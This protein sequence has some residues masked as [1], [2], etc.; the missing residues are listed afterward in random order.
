MF[1][2]FILGKWFFE[3]TITLQS[4]GLQDQVVPLNH[5]NRFGGS[6]TGDSVDDC[7]IHFKKILSEN[8]N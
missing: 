4:I 6:F 7:W 2:L 3:V 8:Q 5:D 1:W